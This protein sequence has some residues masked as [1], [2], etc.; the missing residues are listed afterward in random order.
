MSGQKAPESHFGGDWLPGFEER[1]AAIQIHHL[2]VG[3]ELDGALE[4]VQG[5]LPVTVQT[6]Q[7][8]ALQVERSVGWNLRYTLGQVY[9]PLVEVT[10]RCNGPG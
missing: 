6:M 7:V 3:I 4:V 9:D 5:G 8:A 10:M 2:E 1:H